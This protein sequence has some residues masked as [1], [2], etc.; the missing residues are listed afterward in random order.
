MTERLSTLLHDEAHDL[1]I[2]AAPGDAILSRGRTK[3]RRRRIGAVAGVA[4]VASLGVA[5]TTGP[6]LRPAPGPADGA[7]DPSGWAVSTGSTVHLGNGA[8]AKLPAKIKSIYYTSAGTVVRTGRRSSTDAPDSAYAL[9]TDDG[10]VHSLGLQLGDRAPSTDPTLPYLAYA[11]PRG[12]G[13][14]GWNVVLRDVDTGDVAASVAVDGAFTW[15]GWNAPPVALDGDHVYVALDEA[16][17]D[18]DWRTGQVSPAP[19][20]LGSFFPDVDGGRTVLVDDRANTST[21][22]DVA[23]GRTLMQTSQDQG[24]LMLSPD[25]RFAL[26]VGMAE[27]DEDGTC[28]M[29]DPE[30]E[31]LDVATGARIAT[32]HL[33]SRD[34]GWT[35]DDRVLTTEGGAV[36]TCSPRTGACEPTGTRLGDGSIKVGGALY[37]S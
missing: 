33:D 31:V 27:C 24:Q 1:P 8:T 6:D 35:P 3:V 36:E 37:E 26:V 4:A 32:L 22:V 20:M 10:A 16:T 12:E 18:V 2:P 7:A 17:L 13:H 28:T 15:G 5:L 9:V 30:T 19:H 25:G 29:E 21:V 34:F 11:E 14:D 23:T